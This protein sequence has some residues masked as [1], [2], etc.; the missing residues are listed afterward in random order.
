MRRF[1][2]GDDF[3]SF[4]VGHTI[5]CNMNISSLRKRLL[6]HG[7]GV[8]SLEAGPTK[9]QKRTGPVHGQRKL[10]QREQLEKLLG[11]EDDPLKTKPQSNHQTAK[12]HTVSFRYAKILCILYILFSMY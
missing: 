1:L 2:Q 7:V 12:D 9:K 10:T 5:R 4:C 3:C 6:G 8:D 11:K